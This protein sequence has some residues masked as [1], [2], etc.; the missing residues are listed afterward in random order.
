MLEFRTPQFKGFAVKYSPFIDNR[1]AVATGQHYGLLGSGRVYILRILPDGRIEPETLYKTP[2]T[3]YDL[4]FSEAHESHLL[5]ASGDGSVR[6]FDLTVPNHPVRVWTSHSREVYSVHW[7]LLSKTT[8]LSSSW[9]GRVNIHDPAREDPITVLPTHTC[10]YSAQFSPHDNGI[11][12]AV[13]SDSTIRIFDLR[14][15]ASSANHLV[16]TLANHSAPSTRPGVAPIQQAFPPHEILTHDWNKYRPSVLATGGVDK[17]LRT[18]DIRNPHYPLGV[19]SGHEYGVRKVAWSPH[20]ADVLL[21]AS[22][23]MSV[24]VWRDGQA[25]EDGCVRGTGVM[26]AHTEFVTG[27]DWCMFGM[28]G[29]C[30]STAWDERVLVWDAKEFFKGTMG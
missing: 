10:T 24:R 13:G 3:L 30:A 25:E 19:G 16:M 12:S 9:D 22:Y 1:L 21:T 20:M 2:D 29:W 18:F 27:V 5:T 26:G 6:L 4:T 8:F 15:P 28:E 7:N 14:V 17:L 11:V 23:D